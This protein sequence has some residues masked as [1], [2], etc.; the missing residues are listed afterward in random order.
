MTV[1]KKAYH[2]SLQCI[3]PKSQIGVEVGQNYICQ[4]TRPQ[5]SPGGGV[6]VF[7]V[8]YHPRKKKRKEKKRKESRN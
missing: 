1:N 4:F 2:C 5:A 7:E 8:G 6:L 3:R